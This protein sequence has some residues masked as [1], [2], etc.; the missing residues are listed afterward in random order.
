M[1]ATLNW[2]IL[3][4]GAIARSFA[5]HLRRSRTGRLAAAASRDQ[6]RADAFAR[7]HGAPRGH[8]SYDAL[9]RDPGVQ[10]VYVATPHTG[11]ADWAIRACQAG[12][13]VLCEKP[14]GV[15]AGE[16]MAM[17]QAARA[18]DVFLMEAFMYRCAPQTRRLIEL[19]RSGAIGRVRT[20][21]ASFSFHWPPT[22]D[23]GGRI[24]DPHLA[25]G[26]IL[27][28][29]CYP[30]SL[31]RLV[32]GIASGRPFADPVELKAVGHVGAT[33]VD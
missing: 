22:V 31:A 21:Q 24:V 33:G 2:G 9:L 3:G 30:V 14:L 5:T 18:H 1:T 20:I 28:V 7:E 11:H 6:A 4:T 16:A 10:A 26:G 12:K 25:G 23:E 27:D 13:H 19:L 8:G 29:G 17:I 15:N 32:A